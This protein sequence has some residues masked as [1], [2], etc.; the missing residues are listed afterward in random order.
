MAP[1][2]CVSSSGLGP[3]RLRRFSQ[4]FAALLGTHVPPARGA[5]ADGRPVNGLW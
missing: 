4:R 3:A 1:E 2:P 5:K